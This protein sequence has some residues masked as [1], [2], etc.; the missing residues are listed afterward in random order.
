[1]KA[2]K[3]GAKS[4]NDEGTP[5]EFKYG[6]P[7]QASATQTPRQ[8]PCTLATLG[9]VGELQAAMSSQSAPMMTSRLYVCLLR[10][11]NIAASVYQAPTA[12]VTMSPSCFQGVTGQSPAQ[13]GSDEEDSDFEDDDQKRVPVPLHGSCADL[14]LHRAMRIQAG[15]QAVAGLNG[16]IRDSRPR[17]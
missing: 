15:N 17:P 7:V 12:E 10:S 13:G 8:N 14:R 5:S 3:L 9:A 1:M 4:R 11:R 16:V 2:P 6:V